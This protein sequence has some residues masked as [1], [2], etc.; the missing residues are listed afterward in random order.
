MCVSVETIWQLFS[1]GSIKMW[2][3]KHDETETTFQEVLIMENL[4]SKL[5]SMG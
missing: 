2:K 4:A 3:N 5:M 1:L